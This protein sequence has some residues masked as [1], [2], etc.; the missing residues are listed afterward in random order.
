MKKIIIA[1]MCLCLTV[2]VF[3]ACS[4]QDADGETDTTTEKVTEDAS[5]YDARLLMESYTAKELKMSEDD[6]NASRVFT[7]TQLVD[8]DG[9]DEKFVQVNFQSMVENGTDA[10]GNTTYVPDI[11]GIYYVSTDYK[12]VLKQN[13]VDSLDK[14]VEKITVKAVPETTT[15]DHIHDHSDENENSSDS[16]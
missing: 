6:F 14:G 5:C 9:Y 12:I 4:K 8:V 11:K 2:C 15:S 10:N 1:L 7:K 3:T 13:D 16:K